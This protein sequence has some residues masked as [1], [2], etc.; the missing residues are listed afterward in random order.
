[1]SVPV[2]ADVIYTTTGTKTPII[3]NRWGDYDTSVVVLL[4][5]TATYTLEATINR[6]NRSTTIQ[7]IVWFELAGLVDI[8]TDI[9]DSIKNTPLEAIRIN[10]TALSDDV[11]FQILQSGA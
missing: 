4:S 2:S 3:L 6:L 5:G 8:T 7:P 11:R 10:I 9:T 1:M